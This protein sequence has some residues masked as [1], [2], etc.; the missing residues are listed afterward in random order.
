MLYSLCEHDVRNNIVIHAHS[1]RGDK[2]HCQGRMGCQRLY[3]RGTQITSRGADVCSG[4][5]VRAAESSESSRD[6]GYSRDSF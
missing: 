6:S 1:E 5:L 4:V 2:T 3:P